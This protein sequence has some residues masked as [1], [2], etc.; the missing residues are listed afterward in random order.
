MNVSSSTANPASTW[1]RDALRWGGAYERDPSEGADLVETHASWVFL[2]RDEVFKVKRPVNLGFLDFRTSE[3]R[4][5]AC[6][7]EVNLNRRL[8]PDVYL[9][10]VPIVRDVGGR[11]RTFG[12]G[13]V[14]DWAVRM[15]RLP[16][17]P[18]ADRLLAAGRLDPERLDRI[19]HTLAAFHA[20]CGT[21][22]T[23]ARYGSPVMID[24]NLEENFAQTAD[25][26]EE[27]MRVDE[28][29]DLRRWQ[30]AF[31]RGH[32]AT[33]ARRIADGRV[34]DGHGDLRLEHVYFA[35]PNERVT[36][37]DCIEFNERFRYADV[38]ADLAFLSMDLAAHGRVD[39]A[40]RF[41]AAYARAAQDFDLYAVVDFYESYRAFVRG[42]VSAMLAHDPSVGA[43]ARRRANEEA[44][45]YFLLALSCTRRS[46]LL[47]AV[48]A[49]GGVIASG[50]STIADRIGPDLGAPV[51]DSDRT[52][53][54]MMGVDLTQ[55]LPD[56]AWSGAYDPAFTERVY[57]EVLRRADV[58]LASG[59]PVVIDA[60]FRSGAMRAAARELANRHGVPFRFVECRTA[61][62]VC[63]RRLLDREGRPGVSDGRTAIFDEFC[64]RFE[65][66]V[67]LAPPEHVVL[68]GGRPVE[69]SRG[70][71]RGALDVWPRGFGG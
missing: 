8:A 5:I 3:Q 48:V 65:P 71:L 14:V 2:R 19:A 64:A 31:L 12:P 50:K 60:S 42:K 30:R 45:R 29:E 53:K 25:S 32:A 40:E 26:I 33:F 9:G 55:R 59:R 47:P 35:G 54:A 49:V 41:L 68:D 18:R 67:D 21:D 17:E 56:R 23:I 11:A 44:R 63:R 16:D 66:V 58:V 61:A 20:A 43:D 46:L 51:V 13:P 37:L 15:R 70:I 28:A 27:Y 1:L 38:C 62:D 36:I 34:R 7:A 24:R 69:E 4:R 6:E 57:A 39:L 10:V 22:A 52:R